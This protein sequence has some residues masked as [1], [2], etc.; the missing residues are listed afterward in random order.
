MLGLPLKL[1]ISDQERRWV[2]EGFRRLEKMLG[3]RRM[4]D[5]QVILPTLEYFPDPYDNNPEAAEKLLQRVC[6]YMRVTRSRIEFEIFP[7]ETEELRE[8]LPSWSDSSGKFTAGLYVPDERKD[9]DMQGGSEPEGSVVAI[10]STLL[11]DPLSLVATVAHELGHV[12]LLGVGLRLRKTEDHEPMTDLLTVFLGLGVFTAN[13]AGRFKQYQDVRSQGWSM[14]R[15]GY[16]TE[17]IYGYALAR[18]A[19]ERGEDKPEWT[20]HLSTNVRAY[21]KRSRAWL[22]KNMP[23]AIS[24][25]PIR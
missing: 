3:R 25:H 16:L 7:D 4:L 9:G 11:K 17:Q 23:Q 20:K 6:G 22:I 2:D 1:P 19:M 24:S 21:F 8:I 5:A 14:Q 15:L 10:R 13:S 18:F 12:I